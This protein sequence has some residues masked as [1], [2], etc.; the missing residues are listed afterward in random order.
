MH[1]EF[2]QSLH[3]TSLHARYHELMIIFGVEENNK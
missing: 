2:Q 1:I 3:D